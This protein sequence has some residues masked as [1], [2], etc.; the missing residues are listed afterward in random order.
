MLLSYVR[1]K[2]QG[3]GNLFTCFCFGWYQYLFQ[4]LERLVKFMNRGAYVM[5]S[6]HGTGFIR[7]TKDV[8]N[9]YM[10][11]IL[12]VIVTNEVIY[13]FTI[14]IDFVFCIVPKKFTMLF[15]QVTDGVLFLG[16]WIAICLSVLA[17]WAFCSS[18]NLHDIMP[19]ALITTAIFSLLISVAIFMVLKSAVDTIVLCVLEDYERNDGSEEK[20][21]YLSLKIQSLLFKEQSE[22]V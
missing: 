10:R 6:V 2:L 17:A 12:K 14:F 20:P 21:Y 13:I 8:F 5:S 15:L 7:S 4:N 16:S 22:N 1:S 18:Q 11:N 9:L 19:A 3:R